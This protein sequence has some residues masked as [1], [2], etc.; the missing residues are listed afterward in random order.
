MSAVTPTPTSIEDYQGLAIWPFGIVPISLDPSIG[1]IAKEK[2][3]SAFR[4]FN[5]TN[6]VI[7]FTKR[8]IEPYWIEFVI[9]DERC[10]SKNVDCF[11]ECFGRKPDGGKQ[12]IVLSTRASTKAIVYQVMRAIGYQLL[13][14]GL[15][16]LYRTQELMKFFKVNRAGSAPNSLNVTLDTSVN[17]TVDSTR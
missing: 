3:S 16:S 2:I 9:D 17:M 10:K 15:I 4:L 14:L 6:N 7:Q 8:T 13:E 11:S 1:S 12:Q 5:Q